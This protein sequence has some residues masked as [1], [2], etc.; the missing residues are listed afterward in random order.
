MKFLQNIVNLGNSRAYENV[1]SLIVNLDYL[2][3]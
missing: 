1:N 3:L 2:S